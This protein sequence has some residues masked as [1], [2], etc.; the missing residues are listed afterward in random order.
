MDRTIFITHRRV[1]R[2]TAGTK[3]PDVWYLRRE[4]HSWYDLVRVAW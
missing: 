3:T 4:K 2:S 1:R